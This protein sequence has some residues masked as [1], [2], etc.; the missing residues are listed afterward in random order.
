MTTDIQSKIFLSDMFD[1][2]MEAIY[3]PGSFRT[4]TKSRTHMMQA[5]KKAMKFMEALDTEFV[6]IAGPYYHDDI[7]WDGK[8]AYR[9]IVNWIA[10]SEPNDEVTK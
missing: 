10:E 3:L 4:R 2:D 1:H 6:T 9:V 7:M 5:L 8:A